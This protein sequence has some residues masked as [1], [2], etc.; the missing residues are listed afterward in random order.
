MLSQRYMSSID[1]WEARDRRQ[2]YRLI[3]EAMTADR[4][5]KAKARLARWSDFTLHMEPDELAEFMEDFGTPSL[6][7][8]AERILAGIHS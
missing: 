1:D 7:A 3:V 5:S 4:L 2:K 6:V 8:E